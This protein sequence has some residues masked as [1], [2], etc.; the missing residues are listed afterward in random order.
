MPDFDELMD[1]GLDLPFDADLESL[2]GELLE[3]GEQSRR[4]LY[5]RSQPTRLFTNQLRAHLLGTMAT[6]AAAGAVAAGAGGATV[7][8]A[9]ADPGST[10][11]WVP[12]PSGERR[13]PVP[14]EP[15][16]RRPGAGIPLRAVLALLAVAGLL[17]VA[18]LG[19][20]F[21]ALFPA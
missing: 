8:A 14:A 5:G 15:A 9:D 19:G 11:S 1:P 21:E 20:S 17:V 16:Q 2:H 3:A 4:M 10:R 12:V 6:P 13:A 18:A 7:P